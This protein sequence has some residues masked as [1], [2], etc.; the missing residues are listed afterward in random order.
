MS[1]GLYA[2]CE[3][4]MVIDTTTIT[5]VLQEAL[6]LSTASSG[7]LSYPSLAGRTMFIQTTR[8]VTASGGI[9][10]N[11]GL[12]F[13]ISYSAGYPIITYSPVGSGADY[14]MNVFVMVK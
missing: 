14:L 9:F 11:R 6:S 12:R 10:N 5:G 3:N 13:D 8:A 2:L 1:Y 4:G 7:T